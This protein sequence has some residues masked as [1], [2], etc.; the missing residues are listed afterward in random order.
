MPRSLFQ[1]GIGCY[2]CFFA[3]IIIINP[4]IPPPWSGAGSGGGGGGG[5]VTPQQCGKACPLVSVIWFVIGIRLSTTRM[6]LVKLY[7]YHLFL[8]AV[9]FS[10][11]PS[12]TRFLRLHNLTLIIA[13]IIA[14][15]KSISIK[16]NNS[17]LFHA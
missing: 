4:C 17:H 6:K 14:M 11:N 12:S 13:E 15:L 16:L 1:H 5:G 7:H 3:V 2:F 9:F 10:S 8:V